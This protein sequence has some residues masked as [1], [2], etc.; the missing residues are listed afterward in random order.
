MAGFVVSA[1]GMGLDLGLGVAVRLQEIAERDL[2]G[3]LIEALGRESP[4]MSKALSAVLSDIEE[5][6]AIKEFLARAAGR[7]E[8]F[9]DY[10]KK[11]A[12]PVDQIPSR[13]FGWAWK[14]ARKARLPDAGTIT[15]G[16]QGSVTAGAR[17][18]PGPAYEFKGALGMA[19]SAKAPFSFGVASATA[20][21][22][23][24]GSV[25]MRFDHPEGT[26]VIDAIGLDLPVVANFNNAA[27]LLDSS[28]FQSATLATSGDVRLGAKLRA[29]QTWVDSFDAGGGAVK[30]RL[31]AGLSYSVDWTKAGRYRLNIRRA[32]GNRLRLR[33]TESHK[34]KT[35][36]SLSV[37]A[38]V[39]IR[40]L[41][42]A[43]AP[44]LQEIAQLPDSLD[45]LV[46]TYSEPSKIL[47]RRFAERVESLDE[48][49]LADLSKALEDDAGEAIEAL[50]QFG[51]KRKEAF[52]DMDAAAAY[53]L[54][55]LKKLLVRYRELEEQVTNAVEVTEKEK[56]LVR[57][58]RSVTRQDSDE[59]LLVF[60]LNPKNQQADELY[61]KMLTGD[62]SE[63]M[64]AGLDSGNTA[65]TL[66]NC[67]FKRMFS[68]QVTSGVTF[69]LFGHELSRSRSLSAQIKVQHGPGGQINVFAAEGSVLKEHVAF[70]EGQSMRVGSLM[71]WITAPEAPDAFVVAL[72]YTDENMKREEL[73][74][75]MGSLEDA[76]LVA[77]GAT[78]QALGIYGGIGG[79]EAAEG[80]KRSL[81]IDTQ[82]ALTRDEVRAITSVG[83]EKIIRMAIRKQLES[84]GRLAWAAK[85]LGQLGELLG[86]EGGES[87]EKIEDC[88]FRLRGFG[89]PVILKNN[90]LG[91]SGMVRRRQEERIVSLIWAIADRAEDLASFI[92]RWRELDSVGQ[93]TTSGA[94]A[95]ENHETLGEFQLGTIRQLHKDML[96]DLTQW[97]DTRGLLVSL[98]REDL[99]PIATAFLTSLRELSGTT[100]NPLIPIASWTEDGKAQ[101]VALV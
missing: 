55:P 89:R 68:D 17:I 27:F 54:A 69:N 96:A 87:S 71:N 66:K 101:Q 50:A 97:V 38:E 88:V 100:G 20:R 98:A 16:L 91:I 79:I 80:A 7:A 18:L 22:T 5:L 78:E 13:G 59:T 51:A 23:R 39:K 3:E 42:K 76:G 60:E 56:L 43:L 31:R 90:K 24:K 52:D 58:A 74:E 49:L 1:G 92:G 45:E 70:G 46:K 77:G 73:R 57:Y 14:S 99:S 40:G 93:S 62:F 19:G 64:T 67:V 36:R 21:R 4:A 35:A 47:K 30:G 81:S 94:A 61:R 33:L 2:T 48:D 37:G 86:G 26:R 41:R 29:S 85:A 8:D 10:L 83:E 95:V 63:A 32:K 82:L 9:E 28:A 15:L 25:R 12:G 34:R 75:Y 11:L 84:Y 65:I 72:N 44:L 53:C 6:Q